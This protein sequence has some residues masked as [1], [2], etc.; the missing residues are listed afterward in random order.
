MRPL[1]FILLS[2][3]IISSYAQVKDEIR[4]SIY[5]EGGSYTIG[6]LQMT[7]LYQWLDSIPHVTE[8]YDVHLISHTDPIGG[9]QYNQWLSKKRSQAVQSLLLQKDIAEHKITI[10]DWGLE[11]PVYENDSYAGMQMNRRVDIIPLFSKLS[12]KGHLYS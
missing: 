12:G 2:M 3:H 1:F 10:K 4:K 5:F 8:N 11:N 7:E 9:Q 6:S